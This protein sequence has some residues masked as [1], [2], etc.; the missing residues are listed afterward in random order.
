MKRISIVLAAML[1]M[2]VCVP[3]QAATQENTVRVCILDSGCNEE[4]A[5]GKN[6]LDGSEDLSDEEGH[7]TLVYQILKENAP[8][9][10]V[11]VQKC[12]SD[13]EALLH[14]KENDL[15][16]TEYIMIQAIYDAVDIYHADI[17]N[18]SWTLNKES[19]KLHKAIQYAAKN[20]VILVA[21]AG[22]LSFS[23]KLG[24]TVYPAAWEEVIGVAGADLDDSG[25]PAESLWY[26]H[27]DAVFVSADGNYG[28]EKGSSFA[29]PRVSAVI[30]RYLTDKQG[31]KRS[32]EEVKSYLKSIAF[33]AGDEGYDE[34]FG[35]G[36]ISQ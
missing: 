4:T 34:V 5:K 16:E 30:A 11:Y 12:F 15:S 23:T 10:E 8:D 25:N 32:P 28:N 1:C 26:L 14:E 24:S 3:I 20:K 36:Y 9:A 33:D 21:A 13:G 27:S 2:S 22:N 31:E 35:W 6:Y 19:E 7:G 29:T 17:I 18:M